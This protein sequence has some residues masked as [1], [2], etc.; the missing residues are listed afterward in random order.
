MGVAEMPVIVVPGNQ[1]QMDTMLQENL[2][3]CG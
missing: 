1:Y 2:A 3:R